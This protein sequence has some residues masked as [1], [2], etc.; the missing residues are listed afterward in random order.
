MRK[1]AIII[2]I[3]G[4]LVAICGYIIWADTVV[5]EQDLFVPTK[6]TRLPAGMMLDGAPPEGLEIRVRGPAKIVDSLRLHP[7]PPYE[8]DLS[9]R[10]PGVH[11]L[12]TDSGLIELPRRVKLQHI[13]P[14]TFTLRIAKQVH[15]QL[16][17]QVT[18][19]GTPNLG[20]YIAGLTAEPN[21]VEVRGP[22]NRLA[23]LR[24]APTKHIDISAADQQVVKD[25]PLELP[26]GVHVNG[27]QGLIRATIHIETRIVVRQFAA[28]PVAGRGSELAFAIHP[29]SIALEVK[30][31][32]DLLEK[33][34]AAENIS[35]F[36]DL[37]GLAPGV[38][39]RRASITLPMA[40]ILVGEV[41]PELFTVQIGGALPTAG[42]QSKLE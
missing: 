6:V 19:T 1:I 8:L 2:L 38:Y 16:P 7:L 22:A 24:V 32:S 4:F 20:Y 14:Q 39:V 34:H 41:E 40:A 5:V 3:A 33:P 23:D 35:A 42:T 12:V 10:L 21:Q 29:P 30:G 31:P 11:T 13:Y 36:V 17:V 37:A 28:I 9:E 15:K 18:Y 25:I 26:P 27:A